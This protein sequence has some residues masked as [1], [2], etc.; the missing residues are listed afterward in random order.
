MF[1]RSFFSK[2]ICLVFFSLQ[3]ALL[4][5][6]N[7]DT[8]AFKSA[9][10][11]NNIDEVVITANRFETSKWNTPDAI[12]VSKIKAI[13]KYQLR[14][15]PEALGII[16]GVFVQKTNHGGGSPF[17]RG[18]TGNQTLLLVDGI[19]LSNSTSRYGPNQYLNTI[20]VFNLEKIEVLRGNGSVQYGSD[21]LGG[22]IQAFSQ[23]LDFSE[24][25]DWGGRFLARVASR[26]MEKTLHSRLT[27]SDK[28][29]AFTTGISLRNFGD[30][31][32][33]NSTQIQT[34]SGYKEL[35]CDFKGKIKLTHNSVLTLAYQRAHQMDV[36]I[37]HKVAL[38]N[39][40]INR[41]HP[42]K[43]NLAYI[44]LNQ[45]INS[46]IFQSAVV[47]VCLNRTE[48]GRESHKN[49]STTF[50]NE[51]DK[52]RTLAIIADLI[53]IKRKI[54]SSNSG[55]EYYSDLVNSSRTETNHT[56]QSIVSKRGLYP[57]GSV[58]NSFSV[59]NLNN[60]DF[61]KWNVVAG[62]R[63]N[64]YSITVKD[65]TLGSTKL[66]PSAFVGNLSLMRKLNKNTNLFISTNTGY[67]APNIDDLGTLGI[68]DF[69]YEV[70]NYNLEPEK[71][72]QYQVGLKYSKNKLRFDFFLYHNELYNLIARNRVGTNTIEG[73]PV[74]IKEN[75]E[76]GYIQGLESSA[77]FQLTQNLSFQGNIT[78]TF[79]Q[80][81]TKNEPMRRIPPAFGR[82]AFNYQVKNWSINA[83]WQSA[84][85]QNR[86]SQG[87][88]DDNRIPKGGTP[89]WSVCNINTRYSWNFLRLD[90]SFINLFNIDYRYHGSGINGPG[91]SALLTLSANL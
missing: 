66:N 83:E 37:Y 25:A 33:G 28:R 69:R 44:R 81:V 73:Y 48:E 30:L 53:G 21:A 16:P 88:V 15:S 65:K 27:Y 75:V 9:T 35:N 34:P 23:Q 61:E 45:E 76:R 17:L 42:Q 4:F 1:D 57:N 8:V 56:I 43:R 63:F 36:P 54:W 78:Y 89:G 38:E 52:V 46:K 64:A 12:E 85:L 50:R 71:S 26:G 39:F 68:V 90:L 58:M 82:L 74:Y 14:T 67:R 29:I 86:L 32:G 11:A 24:K 51:N 2:V 80:N 70:P 31:Y 72:L 13:E 6:Q 60:F 49:G 3:S 20:D 18:L 55:M 47:T 87:D 41:I 22:T 5:G 62:A 79:G 40:A 77:D 59:F 19:R 7:K 10:I 84:A 91:R